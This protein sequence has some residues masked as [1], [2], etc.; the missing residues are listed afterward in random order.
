MKRLRT[1]ELIPG[2]V[3][4]EDVY[5]YSNQLILPKGLVLTDKAI[6]K[7]EFYSVLM[8]RVE[9][10]ISPL[11]PP[12][13]IEPS[14]SKRVQASQEFKE[15]KEKFDTTLATF[16]SSLQETLTNNAPLNTD[17]LLDQILDMIHTENGKTNVFTMLHNMREY[18][19]LTFAHSLNVALICHAFA[20][21]LN[22]SKEDV[23]LATLCG[24]LHDVGKTSIPEDIIKKPAKLTSEEYAIAKTHASEGYNILRKYSLDEHIINSA[25]MH[26]E[27]F[28]GTGYPLGLRQNIDKFAKIVA[29]A[30]V[31]EA[32]TA[33]RIYRGPLCPFAVIDLFVTE[34]LQKF[35]TNAILTFLHNIVNNY[36]GNTVRLNNKKEGVIIFINPNAL[37]RPTIKCGD[38]FID[39]STEPKLYI[40]AII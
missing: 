5:T 14:Y 12:I 25:L 6:T 19:D 33:T 22:Y 34:G 1:Q 40:E 21:W 11:T 18:D 3:T 15:Y 23:H 26:H 30:D 16:K 2:M 8:V 24:L 27:R 20:E 31:Y 32:M 29:I 13:I 39:L 38:K 35:D 9:D 17:E 28:D 4:A 36:L 37:S 10:D 7:L